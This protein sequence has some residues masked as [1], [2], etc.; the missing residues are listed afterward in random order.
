MSVNKVILLGNL[1]K[2]P[3]TRSLTNGSQVANF[4]IATSDKWTDKQTGEKKERTE[5]HRIVIF[6]QGLIDIVKR[7]VHKGSKL[8][9]E[10]SLQTRKWTDNNN[11]DKYVTEIVLQGY[12][13]SLQLLDNKDKQ[14]T[15][16]AP[17]NDGREFVDNAE[18]ELIDDDIPF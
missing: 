1:T 11:N 10:G 13:C 12:G 15:Q 16:T 7:Y 17:K 3:E 9:I 5:Y 8:Y 4:S 2:D 6:Q 18:E 14:E